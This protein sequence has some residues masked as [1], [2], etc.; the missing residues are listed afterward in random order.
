[1]ASRAP[2]NRTPEWHAMLRR[3]PIRIGTF[4]GAVGLYALALFLFL[5]LLSYKVSDGALNTAAGPVVGNLMGAAG[6]W[7]A[8]LLYTIAGVPALLVLPLILV[9][10]RRLWA[11]QDMAGWQGQ[12]A[13]CAGGSVL[14]GSSRSG[15]SAC[16]RAGAG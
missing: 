7:A 1:M 3:S 15:W 13:E 2:A 11:D 12:I 5:A 10:A 4:A 6:A 8:D 14:I 9:T 16:R